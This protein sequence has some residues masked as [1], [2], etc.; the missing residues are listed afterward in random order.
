MPAIRVRVAW[1][2]YS[3]SASPL[4]KKPTSRKLTT[5]PFGSD[6]HL[7]FVLADLISQSGFELAPQ[8]ID[9]NPK[10]DPP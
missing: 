4:L 2:F 9:V 5:R 6:A 3:S 10:A 8:F 1:P 7:H